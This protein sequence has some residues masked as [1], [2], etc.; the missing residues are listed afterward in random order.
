[1]KLP[2]RDFTGG[3]PITHISKPGIYPNVCGD[4]T[5][6]CLDPTWFSNQADIDALNHTLGTCNTTCFI[7]IFEISRL[8]FQAARFVKKKGNRCQTQLLKN[9]N[10]CEDFKNINEHPT[11]DHPDLPLLLPR[12]R[13]RIAHPLPPLQLQQ[14]WPQL[15]LPLIFSFP[16]LFQL[17]SGVLSGL[18]RF[19][20]VFPGSCMY[21]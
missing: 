1:M 15:P 7:Y 19:E 14:L 17:S 10:L 2:H 6:T 9:Q 21:I 8:I 5:L 18:N 20:I 13:I 12:R 3:A 16:P 11:Q 4:H